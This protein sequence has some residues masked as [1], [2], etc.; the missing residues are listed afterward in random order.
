MKLS[1]QAPDSMQGTSSFSIVLV[2]S[3]LTAG[4][5]LLPSPETPKR[6]PVEVSTTN[7]PQNIGD[8]C[9]YMKADA[10]PWAG[11]SGAR[12][13]LIST[14]MLGKWDRKTP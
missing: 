14:G 1:Q 12:N 13:V 3:S 4:P 6:Q 10:L 8:K 11:L 2:T 9:T 5:R 7:L